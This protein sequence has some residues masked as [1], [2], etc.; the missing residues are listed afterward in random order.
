MHMV[1]T[2]PPTVEPPAIDRYE[3]QHRRLD[4][5]RAAREAQ[6]RELDRRPHDGSGS[7][8]AALAH[9]AAVAHSLYATEAALARM[10]DGT[11]GACLY[12]RRSIP[13][14][15][16][17]HDPRAADCVACARRHANDGWMP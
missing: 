17:E 9:R 3:R 5:Q 1:V 13:L 6:L 4:R 2:A 15:R 12:C 10:D 8:R 14:E 11:Y 7:G 16:L